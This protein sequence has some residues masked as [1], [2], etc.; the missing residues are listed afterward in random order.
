MK[1]K[2]GCK[3]QR[4]GNKLQMEA[5]GYEEHWKTKKREKVKVLSKWN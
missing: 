3:W 4:K 5:Q 1:N 2:K